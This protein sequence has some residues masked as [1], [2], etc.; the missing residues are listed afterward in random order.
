MVLLRGGTAQPVSLWGCV[1]GRAPHPAS[2][3]PLCPQGWKGSRLA[4]LH[5]RV[6][7]RWIWGVVLPAG[8]PGTHPARRRQLLP[9]GLRGASGGQSHVPILAVRTRWELGQ[10]GPRCPTGKGLGSA[11]GDAGDTGPWLSM[12]VRS[13]PPGASSDPKRGLGSQTHWSLRS[14]LFLESV[15]GDPHCRCWERW[16]GQSHPQH[17]SMFP[18]S[19]D[20]PQPPDSSRPLPAPAGH[21]DPAIAGVTVPAHHL[22]P[23]RPGMTPRK[24]WGQGRRLHSPGAEPGLLS[25]SPSFGDVSPAAMSLLGGVL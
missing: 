8:C 15:E 5:P 21:P 16:H 14:S 24:G 17:S 2:R 4:G 10:C 20:S 6:C 23:H 7:Y 3:Q 13:V 9:R 18:L 11:L 12:C 1:Q 25:G 22:P 19:R